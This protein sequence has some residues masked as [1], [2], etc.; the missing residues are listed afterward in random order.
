MVSSN[1]P[2]YHRSDIGVTISDQ[3]KLAELSRRMRSSD[4]YRAML[5]TFFDV[6]GGSS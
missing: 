2:L 1:Y 5:S 3:I 4:A 6:K